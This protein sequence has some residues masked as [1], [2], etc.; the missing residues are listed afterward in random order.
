MRIDPSTDIVP[1]SV[2]KDYWDIPEIAFL[3]RVVTHLNVGAT[4]A[5]CLWVATQ[6]FAGSGVQSILTRGATNPVACKC[7]LK[8]KPIPPGGQQIARADEHARI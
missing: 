5:L 3:L 6:P 7:E 2:R 1:R 8:L 4:L